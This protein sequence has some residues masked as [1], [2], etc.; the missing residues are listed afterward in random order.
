MIAFCIKSTLCLAS[1]YAFYLLVLRNSKTFHF[2]RFYLLFSLLFSLLIP[3]IPLTTVL[4]PL[5]ISEKAMLLPTATN[6][7]TTLNLPNG[8]IIVLYSIY[9]VICLVLFSR[10]F[11]NLYSL[12][13]Q[14]KY[15]TSIKNGTSH[16][17]LVSNPITPH[18][19][20]NRIFLHKDQYKNGSITQ[21][22]LLHEQAHC[23]QYHSV[24]IVLIEFIQVFC[25]FN[26]FIWLYKKEIQLNHEYLADKVVLSQHDR[27]SYQHT[28][29]T[30]LA[31]NN[32]SLLASNFNYSFTK[33]R[34]L[35]MTKEEPNN[36]LARMLL[37]VPL[38]LF[39][40]VLF[41]SKPGYFGEVNH[42]T[43]QQTTPTPPVPPAPTMQ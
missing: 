33:R 32:T 15:A 23:A 43:E 7:L 34:L 38:L 39:I 29:L 36:K 2:N 37:V 16:L 26:P 41:T 13:R 8:V 9:T 27:K 18:S 5:G 24:D 3:F 28:I 17:V 14:I 19:F 30:L 20:F 21:E 25:W 4:N 31:G 35:M 10:I 40:G 6:E 22:V 1:F 12:I 42:T 11:R